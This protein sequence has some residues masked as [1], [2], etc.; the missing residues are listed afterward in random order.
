[1]PTDTPTALRLWDEGNKL[2][3]SCLSDVVSGRTPTREEAEREDR[4]AR[5]NRL[6]ARLDRCLTAVFDQLDIDSKPP[7]LAICY[8]ADR[9]TREALLLRQFGQWMSPWCESPQSQWTLV[10]ELLTR[11]VADEELLRYQR[12]YA[13]QG[14]RWLEELLRKA[15]P[16]P[17]APTADYCLLS[18]FGVRWEEE[19]TLTP[20]QWRVLQYLL[21]RGGDPFEI[22]CLE[23][24]VWGQDSTTSKNT[25]NTLSKLNNSLECIHFPWRWH[26]R[27]GH[28]HRDG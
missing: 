8:G 5:L 12:E 2:L 9:E 6:H 1:M 20:M 27:R 13:R 7:P 18:G 23:E 16:R 26:V 28:V 17:P 21:S 14:R 3:L 24:A 25:G 22:D 15:P 19:T 11:G 10:R 4:H